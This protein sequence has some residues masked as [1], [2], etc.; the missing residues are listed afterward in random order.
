MVAVSQNKSI[1]GRLVAIGCN[2]EPWIALLEQS[3][4]KTHCCYDLRTA[5][6]I[7]EEYSPCICVVDL[8]NN[9]FS[10]NSISLRAN[11]T[12]QVKWIAI[13]KKEQLKTDAIR[14]FINNFCV[15]YFTVPIPGSHLLDTIG[16]QLGMLDI[17]ASS[18]VEI[19]SQHDMGLFGESK[20]IKQLRDMVRRVAM[21]EVNVFLTGENGTGKELIAKSIHNL[22]KRKNAP[23]V[24]VNCSSLARDDEKLS[25]LDGTYRNEEGAPFDGTLMLDNVEELSKELQDNLLAYLQAPSCESLDEEMASDVRIVATS[26]ADLDAAVANG[27]FSK[28][29]YYRLNV[30]HIKVPT[31]R[32]RGSDIFL[33]AETFLTKFAREYSTMASTFSED[34]K[35][36]LLRYSWP[37][38]VRE[39]IN[40]VKRAALLAEGNEVKAEHFDL[41]SKANLKQSLRNIKDEAEK[42]VLV[43]V[44]ETHRGQVASAAKD[45]GVSRATMYRLLNKHNIVPDVRHYNNGYARE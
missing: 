25:L 21:T 11:K 33:L 32:E 8:S 26:S 35:Q 45:L 24:L 39:L 2:Y 44:L 6:S 14:Q 29:L 7:L 36:L 15:D 38:N 31:L 12:K 23:F 41:P 13:I 1:D 3:G 20:S 9:D 19:T 43:A 28:E 27:D 34:S 4:W 18:W 16:H 22:S 5:D 42:D 37:G 30:F 40:Q 17:E 10:L